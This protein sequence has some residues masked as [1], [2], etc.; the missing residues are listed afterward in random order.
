M[1]AL[2]IVSLVFSVDT[3]Q[4]SDE[5]TIRLQYEVFRSA[6]YKSITFPTVR[7]SNFPTPF[8]NYTV[9]RPRGFTIS[10]PVWPGIVGVTLKRLPLW[11]KH[12][13]QVQLTGGPLDNNGTHWVYTDPDYKVE[14]TYIQYYTL[15]FNCSHSNGSYEIVP[16]QFEEDIDEFEDTAIYKNPLE[17]GENGTSPPWLAW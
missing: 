11:F 7:V 15:L 13:F 8:A 1:L 12:T 9:L 2:Y 4:Y 16:R 17:Q 3:A 5:T 14:G 6:Y 10:C